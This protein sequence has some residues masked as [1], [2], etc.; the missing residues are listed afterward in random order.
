MG[1]K[2]AAHRRR[3]QTGGASQSGAENKHAPSPTPVVF[4]HRWNRT[5][6]ADGGVA[7][8]ANKHFLSGVGHPDGGRSGSR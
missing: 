5:G 4:L 6:P 7:D 1:V 3:G 8:A 2:H